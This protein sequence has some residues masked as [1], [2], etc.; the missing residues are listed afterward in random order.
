MA[1]GGWRAKRG[2]SLRSLRRIT[3][4]RQDDG[5][6]RTQRIQSRRDA[7]ATKVR[8]AQAGLPVPQGQRQKRTGKIAYA[9]RKRAPRAVTRSWNAERSSQIAR[10]RLLTAQEPDVS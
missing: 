1:P 2:P 3:Q 10:N 8:R 4:G 5:E 9:T 6:K 7:G